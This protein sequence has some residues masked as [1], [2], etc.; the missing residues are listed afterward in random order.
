VGKTIYDHP[1]FQGSLCFFTLSALFADDLRMA[2][3][4]KAGDPFFGVLAMITMIIFIFALLVNLI[5]APE[6]RTISGIILVFL[7]L[8]CITSLYW[9]VQR[10]DWEQRDTDNAYNLG[11]WL[12][13]Q[14]CRSFF[15]AGKQAMGA[16]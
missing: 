2:C 13:Y 6:Y 1:W 3:V 16:E 10:F 15:R 9:D 7:D 12:G 8:V 14:N 11:L 5:A 4:P